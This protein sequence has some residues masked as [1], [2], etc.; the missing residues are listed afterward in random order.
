MSTDTYSRHISKRVPN[1][2]LPYGYR[3]AEKQPIGILGYN[4]E[5][6]SILRECY[7]LGNGHRIYSPRL[8]RFISADTLSPFDRGGL[9]CYA[10][11]LNDPINATDPSGKSR[12][13]TAGTVALAAV[14]FKKNL[15]SRTEN[16]NHWKALGNWYVDELSE[17]VKLAI[18]SI[19]N[20]TT[21]ITLVEN[22]A[23]L[24]R[25][26]DSQF[27]HKFIFTR[28]KN[29]FIG[30]YSAD[31]PSHPSIAHLGQWITGTKSDVVSAGSIMKDGNGYTLDSSSGHYMP[32]VEQLKPAQAHLESLGIAVTSLREN[33]PSKG[34]AARL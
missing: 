29:F 14:K 1:N 25:L 12:F 28:A 10:Y 19:K 33:K 15:S 17:D 13:K 31:E 20:Q 21:H 26:N 22:P 24:S 6:L 34:Y 11:C 23:S 30:S 3:N 18:Q 27:K 4:G 7:A 2:Y 8:M 9:N 5:P 16:T 32:S